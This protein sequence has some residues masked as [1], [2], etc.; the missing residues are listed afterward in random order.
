MN[1]ELCIKRV[2]LFTSPIVLWLL[3]QL[4][5]TFDDW[6]YYTAPYMGSL[7][8]SRWLPMDSWWRPF[9]HVFGWIVGLNYRL[10]PTLNHVFV[11]AAH[12][13]NTL[14]VW[15]IARQ[16]R[17]TPFGRTV[18]VG[19][20]YLSPA[21]LG[22]VTGIDSLNQA[23]SHFWGLLATSIYL[24]EASFRGER[25]G[26]RGE[27]IVLIPQSSHSTLL[28]P[29]STL[30]CIL[31][32]LIATLCKENGYMWGI[33][34]PLVAWG[35]QI[36]DRRRLLRHWALVIAL[37]IA[38]LVVRLLLTTSQVD[39]NNEYFDVTLA[40]RLKDIATFV[41]LTWIPIDYVALFNLS[42]QH[43]APLHANGELF[44][45]LLLSPLRDSDRWFNFSTFQLL[46]S[47]A[48]V[49]PFMLYAY[50]RK[51]RNIFKKQ[52]L[53]LFAGIILAA[54]PHLITLFTTMHAYAGL[55]MAALSIAWLIAPSQ[56]PPKGGGVTTA[57]PDWSPPPSGG[58]WE[59]A[60]W[61]S[62]VL[63]ALF[64]I[65]VLA[66]DIHHGI[67]AWKSGLMGR[68][69]GIQAVSKT[70]SPVQ[71]VS[72]IYI[73]TGERRYS[74]FCCIPYE[75]FAWGNT[76]IYQTGYQWP[77]D[78]QYH[79]IAGGPDEHQ[80]ALAL[81][82]KDIDLGNCQCAWIVRKDQIEVVR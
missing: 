67:A 7:F 73:N 81:A 1:Y 3:C 17:F 47:A 53:V 36:I 65:G 24:R 43:A 5:P 51:P 32:I 15:H 68:Q 55:S 20:F 39:I 44:V 54:L 6:T 11:Y 38:Y 60:S 37:G 76:A 8:S 9:D 82:R 28:S 74:S 59:G 42:T 30:L 2:I 45:Q 77:N 35:F 61:A 49:M 72:I 16:L 78:F 80:Q 22:T 41:G 52:H 75:A 56:P 64:L 62:K 14:L 50:F 26:E 34:A 71:R 66:V 69:M 29:L 33:I 18:A 19:F 48:L 70:G 4:L 40:D 13:M 10:F 63:F 31:C 21:M 57:L 23:Y 79:E 27:R 46:I 58:G 12:L 25:R